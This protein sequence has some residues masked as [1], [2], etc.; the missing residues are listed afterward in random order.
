MGCQA[1]LTEGLT[2]EPRPPRPR[3]ASGQQGSRRRGPGA[4]ARR[5]PEEQEETSKAGGCPVCEE[6]HGVWAVRPR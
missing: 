4:G 1:D 3:W 5:S 6:Q 2:V